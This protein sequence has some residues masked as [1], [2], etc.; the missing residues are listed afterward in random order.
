MVF[1]TVQNNNVDALRNNLLQ[2][3]TPGLSNFS[4]K[5]IG[6]PRAF[7]TFSDD[8]FRLG[9]AVALS[10]GRVEDLQGINT[11]DR[12]NPDLSTDFGLPG[13]DGDSVSLQIGF[14]VDNTAEQLFFQYV[15]GSEEFV[16]FGGS[17]FNDSF[18][19]TLN[20]INRAKLR[21]GTTVGVNNIVS[22]NNLAASPQGPFSPDFV[23]NSVGTGLASFSTRIDGYTKPLLF[24]AP[25]IKNAR[26]SL[27]INV[28]DVNDGIFDSTVFIKGGT[29]GSVQ[30]PDIGDGDPG[31]GG[32]TGGGGTGGG[33][34]DGG[35]TGGGTED[36]GKNIVGTS[37][38][39]SLVGTPCDDKIQGLNS[40]DILQGLAGSDVLEGGDGDDR[41]FGDEGNDGLNGGSGQDLLLGGAGNDNLEGGD[42]DDQLNGG[43][44]NDSLMG[45]QGQ[46][47][48]VGETGDDILDG[49]SG[50]NTL[51]GGAGKDTFILSIIGK[52]IIID[53]EEGLDRLKLEGGLAFTTLS[54]SGQSGG[55]QISTI[56]N[57]PIAFL[58]NMSPNL[59]TSVDFTS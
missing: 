22:I 45:G 30:P 13:V 58:K 42:G 34:T 59:I 10:T 46:D 55:T 15:F 31:S 36:C 27:V 32:G 44:G 47:Q 8:P 48:L 14:D 29:L 37:N 21:D 7:G 50:D 1:T 39:D 35:G 52:T 57:Q 54:I 6:D 33:G 3:S 12:S 41:L 17:T 40:Q 24:K 19:L 56:D 38:N 18:S 28:R 26:N 4:V 53:W 2:S 51:I 23:R 11:S 25:L 49:G 9:S 5:L 20:G 43:D 16:E